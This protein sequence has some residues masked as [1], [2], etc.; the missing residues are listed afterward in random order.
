MNI[1]PAIFYK[2]IQRAA[3]DKE[4]S[5]ESVG[6]GIGLSPK[7]VYGFKSAFP[8]VPTIIKMAGAMNQLPS[9]IFA[10]AEDIWFEESANGKE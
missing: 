1:S 4:M 7:S 6:E 5:L 2:A 10:H 8:S 9:D 3:K